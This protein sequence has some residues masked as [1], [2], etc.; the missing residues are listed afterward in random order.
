M[1]QFQIIL[2]L[3]IT[4]LAFYLF[5]KEKLSVDE[6]AILIMVILIITKLVTPEEGVSGFSNS[7]TITVLCMFILSA[8]IR[9]FSGR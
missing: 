2:V 7:A 1:I 4:A 5:I 8:G 6:T 9:I 3:A